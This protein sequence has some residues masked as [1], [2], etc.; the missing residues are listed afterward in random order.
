MESRNKGAFYWAL[1]ALGLRDRKDLEALAYP[2]TEEEVAEAKRVYGVLRRL[3]QRL[4]EGPI[5]KEEVRGMVEA[6]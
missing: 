5:S 6:K 1:E 3:H 4:L 2:K